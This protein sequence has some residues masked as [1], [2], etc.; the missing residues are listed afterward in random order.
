[1]QRQYRK[2]PCILHPDSPIVTSYVKTTKLM[3]VRRVCGSVP[4]F[5][6]VGLYS[7]H[8]CPDTELSLQSSPSCCPATVT[9]PPSSGTLIPE[10]L[11]CTP[12]R[13]FYHQEILCTRNRIVCDLLR[14]AF[15]ITAPLR[16]LPAGISLVWWRPSASFS[17]HSFHA[18]LVYVV[19]M[20]THEDRALFSH[21]GA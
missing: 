15:V 7:Q 9:A 10:P 21:S 6:C 13:K 18:H 17:S 8:C 14:L 16:S 5:T 4:C 2:V 20:H 1:M 3:A 11:I 19:G 12:S